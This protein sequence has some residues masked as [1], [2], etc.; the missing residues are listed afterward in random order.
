[1]VRFGTQGPGVSLQMPNWDAEYRRQ[2]PFKQAVG[3]YNM[4]QSLSPDTRHWLAGLFGGDDEILD[5]KV[6]TERDPIIDAQV[7]TDG[8]PAYG[9]EV[10][11]YT[12]FKKGSEG[13]L[14]LRPGTSILDIPITTE[15]L[16]YWGQL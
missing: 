14:E 6:S 15:G 2:T 12:P 5:A 7:S 13:E 16:E 10:A 8:G 9:E 4:W 11:K 1:M 3:L